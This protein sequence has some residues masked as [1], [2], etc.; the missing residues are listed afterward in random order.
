ME[1]CGMEDLLSSFSSD[2]FAVQSQ[3]E[4]D[5][6]ASLNSFFAVNQFAANTSNTTLP[7]HPW[8]SHPGLT[9]ESGSGDIYAQD[10]PRT[11]TPMG[12]PVRGNGFMLATH[13]NSPT[14][15]H[16]ISGDLTTCGQLSS[17]T[18][19]PNCL[20]CLYLLQNPDQFPTTLPGQHQEGCDYLQSLPAQCEQN[21]YMPARNHHFDPSL[22]QQF[23]PAGTAF[24]R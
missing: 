9:G 21:A 7:T 5:L 16:R 24:G 10:I 3:S 15:D 2:A 11:N 13:Y 18:L 1:T 6:R 22:E 14:L 17:S 20:A 8:S 4:K 12:T 23:V 19:S